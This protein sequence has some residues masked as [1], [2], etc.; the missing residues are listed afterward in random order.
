VDGI[1]AVP[2]QRPPGLV[3]AGTDT[4]VGKTAVAVAIVRQLVASGV[5]VGVYKPVASGTAADDPAGDPWRLWEA[6][7][8]RLTVA[9]VCPQVFRAA[10]APAEAARAEGRTVDDGLVRTG[11][12]VWIGVSDMVVV[13]G[14]GGICSPLS[15]TM[16]VADLARAVGFP[17]VIVDDARLGCI[18]R[19]LATVHAARVLGL[20]VAAV[21]L[22]EVAPPP[23]DGGQPW[24]VD[25]ARRIAAAG[26]GFLDARLAPLP[27]VTLAHGA[28]ATTPVIDW[29]APGR[30][31]R[32]PAVLPGRP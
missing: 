14:A 12:D 18:G 21:V 6:A 9:A 22:S 15:D 29:L 28:T 3:V 25:D 31:S 1:A 20:D 30:L 17:V 13:E 5:R 4:G 10:V 11:I 2:A 19:T 8:R 23:V 32:A 26:R 24:A 16:L 7:G 27:V